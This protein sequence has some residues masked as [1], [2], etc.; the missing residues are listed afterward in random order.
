MSVKSQ[1]EGVLAERDP[2]VPKSLGYIAWGLQELSRDF[3]IA[4]DDLEGR[5]G[6]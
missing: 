3:T 6:N 1:E 5:L 2:S 4:I